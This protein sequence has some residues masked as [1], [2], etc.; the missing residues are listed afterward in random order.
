[1]EMDNEAWKRQTLLHEELFLEL[2]DCA[3]GE[4]E[5]GPGRCRGHPSGATRATT[6][7]MISP[8]SHPF[9]RYCGKY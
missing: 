6:A 8:A 4:C 2:S 5:S 7:P 9:F 1:M 3:G